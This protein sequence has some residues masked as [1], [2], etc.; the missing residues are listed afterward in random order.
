MQPIQARSF[1]YMVNQTDFNS[2]S[3]KQT[4]GTNPA[5]RDALR[6]QS[7]DKRDKWRNDKRQG[8][9]FRVM[10][11]MNLNNVR[12]WWVRLSAETMTGDWTVDGGQLSKILSKLLRKWRYRVPSLEYAVIASMGE[13]GRTPHYHLL[14]TS[15]MPLDIMPSGGLAY[16]EPVGAGHEDR[17][18]LSRYIDKNLNEDAVF[19]SQA[20]RKSDGFYAWGNPAI[21]SHFKPVTGSLYVYVH[22]S[23]KLQKIP[24]A[25]T[26]I[27]DHQNDYDYMRLQPCRLCGHSLPMTT[28][29]FNRSGLYLRNECRVCWRYVIASNDANRRATC[30]HVITR[31][32]IRDLHQSAMVNGM[33]YCYWTHKPIDV[34][35]LDHMQPSAHGGLNVIGNLCITSPRT[36]AQ[37]ADKP[38]SRW[39]YELATMGIRHELQSVY[40]DTLPPVQKSMFK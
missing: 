25:K 6:T 28:N 1:N 11:N 22:N 13:N 21:F 4:N 37:K 31:Q 24:S 7:N 39:L 8:L 10:G 33:T 20:W 40:L 29:Y 35:S 26:P 19:T 27:N 30:G 23:T 15:P 17:V 9:C 38:L 5:D 32:Q 2:N 3:N 18:K 36:N 16:H 34:W 14:T 12:L